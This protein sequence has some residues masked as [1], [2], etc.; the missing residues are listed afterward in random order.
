MSENGGGGEEGGKEDPDGRRP[1]PERPASGD[2]S[3]SIWR[4]GRDADRRRLVL[5]GVN[6]GGEDY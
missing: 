3:R 4:V 1:C 6:A 5:R 2:E